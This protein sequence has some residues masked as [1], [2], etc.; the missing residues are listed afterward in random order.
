[1]RRVVIT[2]LGDVNSVGLNVPETW[3]SIVAGR[4][5]VASTT[6]VDPDIYPSKVTAEVKGYDPYDT[7]DKRTAKRAARFVQFSLTAA[8]EALED[9]GID[10][11]AVDRDRFG[12]FIGVGIGDIITI[13]RAAKKFVERG[14]KSISPFFIPMVIAD[15]AAGQVSIASGLKGPNLATVSACASAT[16]AIGEA[17][18]H[19]RSGR[20]E[21][22][23]AGGSEA[24]IGN[25][26]FG[27][28][29]SARALTT[30]DCPPEE[31]SCP[32]DSKRDGFIM[33]EGTGI[34]QFESLEH[35]Q[36]RGAKIYCELVGYGLSSDGHHLTAPAPGGEGAVRAMKM[37]IEDA[38]LKPTDVDYINA[39]GTSTELNDK[40]E[41]M[42]IKTVFGEH[43]YKLAVNS[44]KSLIGHG[45]GAA[46]GLEAVVVA[47]SIEN[48]LV[49]ATANLTDPSED[50][51]LD[52]VPGDHRKMENKVALSNSPGLGGHNARM[53]FKRFEG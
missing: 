46:G 16:H 1:M 18:D 5:G 43:A 34:L 48:G 2:G 31:A 24:A 26:G 51:D 52:Y 49:H 35:A 21:L 44:T 8:K 20:I 15:M 42:A 47:K 10:L 3:D 50:C 37:A 36:A 33:G 17:F 9:S 53:A 25:L 14:P 40:Y 7:I 41:T 4:F 12:V 29:C 30:R 28:F 32:F 22:M 27:G 6:A 19:I 23:L 38:G 13:E 45:L 11:E 39:H